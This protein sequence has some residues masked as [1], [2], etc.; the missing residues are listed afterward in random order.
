MPPSKRTPPS[1]LTLGASSRPM[2]DN[3]RRWVLPRLEDAPEGARRGV[4][5]LFLLAVGVQFVVML[6]YLLSAAGFYQ[7]QLGPWAAIAIGMLAVWYV[8]RMVQIFM[9]L[10]ETRDAVGA[11]S[12]PS[13]LRLD[14]SCERS[15]SAGIPLFRG[16]PCLLPPGWDLHFPDG[17]ATLEVVPGR[18]HQS[19]IEDS[20]PFGDGWFWVVVG[21]PPSLT[22]ETEVARGLPLARPGAVR[23]RILTA[24]ALGLGLVALGFSGPTWGWSAWTTF[25]DG[26]FEPIELR[27]LDDLARP[28]LR[29][30]REIVIPAPFPLAEAPHPPGGDVELVPVALPPDSAARRKHQQILDSIDRRIQARERWFGGDRLAERETRL[31]RLL[32]GPDASLAGNETWDMI[33]FELWAYDRESPGEEYAAFHA[34]LRR[35][36]ALQAMRPEVLDAARSWEKPI[37]D[38]L[39]AQAVAALQDRARPVWIRGLRTLQTG[40]THIDVTDSFAVVR[41]RILARFPQCPPVYAVLSRRTGKGWIAERG[42]RGIFLSWLVSGWIV[43]SALVVAW[44]LGSAWWLSRRAAAYQARISGI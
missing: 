33:Q 40:W 22:L 1:N 28:D 2:S 9:E 14:G 27:T 35:N 37:L 26:D 25:V 21:L 19:P 38:T 24:F 41:E 34:K 20:A 44:N 4:D 17:P 30:G 7:A 43:L 36:R 31:Q 13:V 3:E 6:L 11:A 18:D 10:G 12:E 15:E 32:E 29:P 39:A 23:R 8:R 16:L 42:G 5:R